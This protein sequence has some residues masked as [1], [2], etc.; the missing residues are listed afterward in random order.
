MTCIHTY[1]AVHKTEHAGCSAR[2]MILN[3][4]EFGRNLG[5][6]AGQVGGNCKEHAEEMQGNSLEK[7]SFYEV[8]EICLNLGES[9]I[10]FRQRA[11]LPSLCV[12][13]GV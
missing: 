12:V 1:Y 7:K 6:N 11:I 13:D 9:R 8:P 4:R 5:S 3:I 10:Y 2:C